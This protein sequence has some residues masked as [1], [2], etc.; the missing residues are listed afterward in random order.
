MSLSTETTSSGKPVLVKYEVMLREDENVELWQNEKYQVNRRHN[1]YITSHRIIFSEGSI[2]IYV[3][4]HYVA[5]CE[6]QGGFFRTLKIRFDI[7]NHGT[8]PFYVS[9]MAR[10]NNEQEPIPP[11]LP[12]SISIKFYGGN[13]SRDATFKALQEAI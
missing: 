2:L 12:E 8:N 11:K 5:N 1:L 3:P 9:E 4:L 6:T 13:A 10:L 7:V